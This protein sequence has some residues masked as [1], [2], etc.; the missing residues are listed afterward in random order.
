MVA[1]YGIEALDGPSQHQLWLWLFLLQDAWDTPHPGGSGDSAVAFCQAHCHGTRSTLCPLTSSLW[2]PRA[3][4]TTHSQD[5]RLFIFYC[6]YAFCKKAYLS[7][8]YIWVIGCKANVSASILPGSRDWIAD[9]QS[10]KKKILLEWISQD[11][12]PHT[13]QKKI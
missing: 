11:L 1:V 13:G 7:L 3:V 6:V 5:I 4:E 2:A 9:C 8:C 12:I 10:W